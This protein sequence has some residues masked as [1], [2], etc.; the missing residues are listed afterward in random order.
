MRA[1][2]AVV[3]LRDKYFL[4]VFSVFCI[5]SEEKRSLMTYRH[6]AADTIYYLSHFDFLEKRG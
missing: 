3:R 5:Y 2:L 6:K 4:T 1:V